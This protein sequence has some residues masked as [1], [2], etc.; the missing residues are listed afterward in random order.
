MVTK[1]LASTA[2]ALASFISHQALAAENTSQD[3]WLEGGIGA[4]YAKMTTKYG[5]NY[6]PYYYSGYKAGVHGSLGVRRPTSPDSSWGM[7]LDL[8][9]TDGYWL[10]TWRVFDYRYDFNYFSLGAYAGAARLYNKSPAYGY[11]L[12]AYG[13]IPDLIAGAALDLSI[14]YRDKVARDKYYNGD[15][16][17]VTTTEIFRDVRMATL[18]LVWSF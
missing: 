2:L 11:A 15:P 7:Q 10:A 4:T 5:D 9:R 14:G 6:T 8:D 1:T 17:I 18:S 12:G 16:D 13:R 3:Y